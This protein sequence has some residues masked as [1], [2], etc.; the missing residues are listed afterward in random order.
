MRLA[1]WSGIRAANM[2]GLDTA[3]DQGRTA[4]AAIQLSVLIGVLFTALALL[5]HIMQVCKSIRAQLA[6]T[7]AS[8]G[9]SPS[10]S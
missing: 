9:P 1:A 8:P 3:W 10:P 7:P 5:V 6:T 4:R 2:G